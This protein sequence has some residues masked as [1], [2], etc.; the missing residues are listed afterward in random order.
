MSDGHR[1]V[2]AEPIKS[3]V[4]GALGVDTDH[5]WDDPQDRHDR[6]HDAAVAAITC[7]AAVEHGEGERDDETQDELERIGEPVGIVEGM[8]GP[9]AEERNPVGP[10]RLDGGHRGGG[11]TGMF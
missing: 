10:E 5:D 1:L 11:T 8:G 4:A 7:P 6:D 3:P 9:G 2:D